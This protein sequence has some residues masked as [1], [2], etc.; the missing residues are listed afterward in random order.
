MKTRTSLNI[1]YSTLI[2]RAKYPELYTI[3]TA[4]QNL[5]NLPVGY[6]VFVMHLNIV[7]RWTKLQ[8]FCMPMRA[9]W[10][11]RIAVRMQ[12]IVKYA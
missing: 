2:T 11:V 9:G 12:R 1:I 4:L 6:E 7:G 10:W 3:Y 8:S 5:N